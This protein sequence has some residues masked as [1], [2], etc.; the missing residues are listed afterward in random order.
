M[1][2]WVDGKSGVAP[3][4]LAAI[5]EDSEPISTPRTSPT[6]SASPVA[7]DVGDKADT[8]PGELNNFTEN[9][10]LWPAEE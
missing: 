5:V 10:E 2:N 9:K 8:A 7:K 1:Q 6:V 4:E 3:K